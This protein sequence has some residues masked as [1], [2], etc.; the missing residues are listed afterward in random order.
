MSAHIT[1]RYIEPP[2]ITHTSK[3]ACQHKGNNKFIYRVVNG[4]NGLSSN[5]MRANTLNGFEKRLD[6]FKESEESW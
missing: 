4:W 5:V 1:R 2:N 3:C 6:K